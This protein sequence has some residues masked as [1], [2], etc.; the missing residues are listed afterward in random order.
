M[1]R[2]RKPSTSKSK[3]AVAAR[4]NEAGNA[5]LPALL[6]LAWAA[7]LLLSLAL[8]G[9]PRFTAYYAA[10]LAATIALVA[11]TL[12]FLAAIYRRGRTDLFLAFKKY[13]GYGL[14]AHYVASALPRVD[15]SNLAL[16]SSGR[17]V[18]LFAMTIICLAV[19]LAFFV[20][21]A[22]SSVHAALGLITQQELEDP[23]LRRKHRNEKKKSPLGVVLEW[24]DALAF[25]AIAVILVNIFIFQ[26]YVVPSES[27]VPVFLSGDRPF[28]AKFLAGPR[29]P[30]TDW[31]LPFA[32][33]PRRGD[34]VTIANPRYPENQHVDLK[35]YLSQLVAMVSFTAVNIDK[36]PDGTPKADPLVK[37]IVG[38]PGEKL[39]MVD[40]VLYVRRSGDAAFA[41]LAADRAYARID[42]WKEP[43]AVRARIGSIRVDEATRSLLSTLDESKR[44]ADPAALAADL[45]RTAAR[46]AS[47][48]ASGGGSTANFERRELPRLNQLVISA[49]DGFVDQAAGGGPNVFSRVG[50]GQA[51]E[52]LP[53][54][55][56]LSRS[57]PLRG[58]LADYSLPPP[59]LAVD[60]DTYTRGT[61]VVDLFIK[62]NLLARIERDLQL[63]A[64]GATIEDFLADKTRSQL[65]ALGRQ[66]A[67]Y[68]TFYDFRNFP[69]FPSGSAFLGPAQYFAMGD[70]RYDSLDFRFKDE[71]PTERALDASDRS[72]I[73]Y[74]SNMEPFALDRRFIEGYA[75]FRIWP[76]SRIGAIR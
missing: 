62:S 34:V 42:L 19:G 16:V 12:A 74:I 45:S 6:A 18:F 73:R 29:I 63:I 54:A 5:R 52:D 24:V 25:A 41:P 7:C 58:Q 68:L 39:M 55:L 51:D 43:D 44:S 66:L 47:D 46:I 65:T 32:R 3:N 60:A 26:L 57:A 8:S 36:L 17:V 23:A 53:L 21:A 38:L 61:R 31:R 35:K 71:R 76:L 72:S 22:R 64:S 4:K 33:L 13:M 49:R 15:W 59:P 10:Y 11:G 37:R 20:T 28:T 9:C 56:A 50:I 67:V 69:E 27:M 2:N 14:V 40:D 48:L 70:N 30:L 1:K 75:L